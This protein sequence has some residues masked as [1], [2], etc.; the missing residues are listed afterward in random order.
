ME[1]SK[2]QTDVSYSV[3]LTPSELDLVRTALE[4]LEDT[5]GREE[6]D[7]LGEVQGL[8]RRLPHARPPG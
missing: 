2:S 8:L 6:A 7:E 1:P 4:I 5:L 3:T